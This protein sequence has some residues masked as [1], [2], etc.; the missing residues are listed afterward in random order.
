MEKQSLEK[1][2]KQNKTKKSI[3]KCSPSRDLK[4]TSHFS[5]PT[6]MIPFLG[7]RNKCVCERRRGGEEKRD[8]KVNRGREE[9]EG[10]RGRMQG[11]DE[12]TKTERLNVFG[13]RRGTHIYLKNPRKLKQTIRM[14]QPC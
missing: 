8:G 3:R 9:A 14:N 2:S 4:D 1:Q 5:H 12:A 6:D 7:K 11:K 10:R 13:K